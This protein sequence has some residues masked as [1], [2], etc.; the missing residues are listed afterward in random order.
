MYIVNTMD[1]IQR[2]SN[3]CNGFIECNFYI[4]FER[5]NTRLD[6]SC[7]RNRILLRIFSVSFHLLSKN[8]VI[9][10]NSLK[11][12]CRIHKFCLYMYVYIK[13]ISL[14]NYLKIFARK[15]FFFFFRY[16]GTI[17]YNV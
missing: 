16:C 1:A 9:K 15:N 13:I 2:I 6:D 14:N 17:E 5:Y 7:V 10:Y 11:I 8:R 12:Y 4:E 3:K